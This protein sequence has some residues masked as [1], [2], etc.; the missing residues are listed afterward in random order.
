MTTN[1]GIDQQHYQRLLSATDEQ[2]IAVRDANR[3]DGARQYAAGWTGKAKF[4]YAYADTCDA[5]LTARHAPQE[6]DRPTR[7][8]RCGHVD[9]DANGICYECGRQVE[10]GVA[11]YM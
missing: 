11:S 4:Y 5:I 9:V 6:P 7:P 3:K 2:L 8:S 10:R 1:R